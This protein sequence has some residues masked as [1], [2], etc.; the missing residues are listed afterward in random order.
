M[1]KQTKWLSTLCLLVGFS[2]PLQAKIE[3]SLDPDCVVAEWSNSSTY[4]KVIDINFSDLTWP[5]TW[6][7]QTGVDC[8]PFSAGGYINYIKQIAAN[9][10]GNVSYPILF[11]NCTFA[12]KKSAGGHGGATAAFSR[13]YYLGQKPS[14]NSATRYNNWTVTGHTK[15]L[16]D[17]ITYDSNGKPNYGEAGFVQMCRD[18]S[19]TTESQHGWMEIDHIPYVERV[20]W[21]WSST[22][23]GRGIKCD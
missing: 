17:N 12:N 4:P 16:E 20:Q 11:H 19:Q 21:S 7:G 10:S 14:G 18:A 1:N 5:D 9:P 22:S 8:P 23:W 2:A 3:G 15:Y 13:I 6:K